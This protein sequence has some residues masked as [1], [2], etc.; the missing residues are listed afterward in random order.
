MTLFIALLLGFAGTIAT[1]FLARSQMI[2]TLPTE[3]AVLVAMS[4][5]SIA[6]IT[7]VVIT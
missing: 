5:H 7:A 1:I 6:W 2:R 4:P 3:G